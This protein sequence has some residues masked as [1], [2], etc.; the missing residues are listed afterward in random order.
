VCHGNTGYSTCG[1]FPVSAFKNATS[2]DVSVAP[3]T[4]RGLH[5]I[6][7]G[8]QSIVRSQTSAKAASPQTHASCTSYLV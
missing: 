2:L 6:Q 7:H 3:D 1:C 5:P 4:N 8:P